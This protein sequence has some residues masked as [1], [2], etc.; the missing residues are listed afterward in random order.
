MRTNLERLPPHDK[1]IPLWIDLERICGRLEKF[2]HQSSCT[3]NKI[4]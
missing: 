2:H 4:K 3:K 1:F